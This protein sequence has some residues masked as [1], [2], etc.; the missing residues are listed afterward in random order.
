M[1]NYIFFYYTSTPAPQQRELLQAFTRYNKNLFVKYS[2]IT[3]KAMRVLLINLDMD[4]AYI[5]KHFTNT[6][7]VT[8]TGVQMKL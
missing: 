4:D 1:D 8:K 7:L 5:E 3:K 2:R 6:N